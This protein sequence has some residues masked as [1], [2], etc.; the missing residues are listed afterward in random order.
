MYPNNIRKALAIAVVTLTALLIGG[1]A[2]VARATVNNAISIAANNQLTPTIAS[3]GS[4]G[5]IITWQDLRSGTADIYAQ[6]INASG[7]VQWT[8]DGVAISTAANSQS[9][10]SITSDG[11]GGAIITWNDLRGDGV[12]S[13]IY[14]QRINASGVV[15]WTEDGV[16]ISTTMT[17]PQY[18]PQIVG[19]GSGGAIIAWWDGRFGN[20]DVYAQRINASG[21][22]L[23]TADGVAIT[24]TAANGQEFPTMASD[25]S[26]GAIIAWQD[27][28]N[29]NNGI[30]DIYAQ[31]IDAGGVVQWTADG[32]AISTAANSQSLPSI[33]SDGSG[34]AII[35]WNDLRG[36]GVISNIYAQRI[37]ASGV[38]QW[39]ADGEAIS[40]T[41]T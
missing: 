34:G 7:A 25:G 9:L 21:I 40:T 14:A 2:T 18:P 31:R 28:R 36:D 5:A 41:M 30:S 13:N 12:I 23:W 3:D 6:R 15:Q 24:P 1:T 17:N 11:S 38:V 10:P 37:N 35:T 20:S 27:N 8:A 29:N 19:D 16:A 22:V 33:T 4:G 26:G 39:T 32:V